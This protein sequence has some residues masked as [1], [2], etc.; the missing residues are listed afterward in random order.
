MLIR[1]ILSHSGILCQGYCC[2]QGSCCR[3]GLAGQQ[4]DTTAGHP[5]GLMLADPVFGQGIQVLKSL[6][7]VTKFGQNNRTTDPRTN[8]VGLGDKQ[9]V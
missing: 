2:Q 9:I 7:H 5:P 6:I 4:G 1:Q 8:A 3:F